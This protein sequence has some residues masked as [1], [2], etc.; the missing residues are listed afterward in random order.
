MHPMHTVGRSIRKSSLRLATVVVAIVAILAPAGAALAEPSIGEIEAQ[1]DDAWGKLEPVI[2]DYNK[3]N[4]SVKK[5][6]T[7]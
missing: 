2:E 4:S 7:K 6:Q 5:N 3:V 1:I